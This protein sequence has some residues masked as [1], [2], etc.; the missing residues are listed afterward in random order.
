VSQV[1][2]QVTPWD[3]QASRWLYAICGS[4]GAGVAVVNRLFAAFRIGHAVMHA[5]LMQ[6]PAFESRL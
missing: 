4:D 5:L 1:L 2:Q 3:C 6:R